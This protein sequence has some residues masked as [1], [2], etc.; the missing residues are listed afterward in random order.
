MKRSRGTT[1][2]TTVCPSTASSRLLWQAKPV[3]AHTNSRPNGQTR[4]KRLGS[5]TRSSISPTICESKFSYKSASTWSVSIS[6]IIMYNEREK[7]DLSPPSGNRFYIVVVRAKSQQL[8][9][10]H[11]YLPKTVK[12]GAK[13]QATFNFALSYNDIDKLLSKL[14][15]HI[16]AIFNSHHHKLIILLTANQLAERSPRKKK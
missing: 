16:P 5:L 4:P 3:T 15:L 9:P 8:T 13:R 12:K 7:H 11:A 14:Q 1:G 6:L 2:P 10:P